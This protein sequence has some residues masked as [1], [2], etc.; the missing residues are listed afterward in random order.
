MEPVGLKPTLARH[1]PPTSTQG[2]G[3]V[4]T[5]LLILRWRHDGGATAVTRWLLAAENLTTP[6]CAKNGSV[7]NCL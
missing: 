7:R 3:P 1:P 4:V 5:P 6:P 2:L